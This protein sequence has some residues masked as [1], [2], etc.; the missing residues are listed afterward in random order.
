MSDRQKL[1][2]WE[3]IKTYR[4]LCCWGQFLPPFWQLAQ[5]LI[6]GR[7]IDECAHG[8]LGQVWFWS[9]LFWR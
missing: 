9:G 8:E 6:V 4:G 3:K 1:P 7:T 5:P 2:D